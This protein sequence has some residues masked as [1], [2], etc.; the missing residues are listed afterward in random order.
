MMKGESREDWIHSRVA[1]MVADLVTLRCIMDLILEHHDENRRTLMAACQTM[2]DHPPRTMSHEHALSVISE[3]IVSRAAEQAE[4]EWEHMRQ[5][6][7]T[8]RHQSGHAH[9]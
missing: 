2:A 5:S 7:R 9:P 3:L 6:R 1:H 8:T 4:N